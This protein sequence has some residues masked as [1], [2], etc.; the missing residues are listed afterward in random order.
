VYNFDEELC[1][2]IAISASLHL[3]Y[4]ST[5]EALDGALNEVGRM[6]SKDG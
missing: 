4:V 2:A 3:A 1:I 6:S 5:H